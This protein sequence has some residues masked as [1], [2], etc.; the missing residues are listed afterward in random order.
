MAVAATAAITVDTMAGIMVD[1][2][3]GHHGGYHGGIT[4]ATMADITAATTELGMA[5]DSMVLG[6]VG[7][8]GGGYRRPVYGGVWTW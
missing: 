3:G 7:G 2:D 4:A 1:I 8:Y 5:A 6:S